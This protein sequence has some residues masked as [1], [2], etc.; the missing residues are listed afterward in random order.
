MELNQGDK[1]FKIHGKDIKHAGE[2]W[3]EGIDHHPLSEEL[4]R[5]IADYDFEY[6]DDYFC[7]KVGGDGDN[8]ETLMYVL[9]MIF[10]A[11]GTPDT[12]K[13]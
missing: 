5:K 13:K 11:E 6:N 12:W 8:G 2:R 7:W 10:E 9:D 1:M 4:V 3:E